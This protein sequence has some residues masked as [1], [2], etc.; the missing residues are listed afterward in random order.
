[1]IPDPVPD[2]G[3]HHLVWIERFQL[4][5][6]AVGTLLWLFH[7][8][9]ASVVFAVSGIGSFAFWHLHRWIVA[10]MLTP[11]VRK[12]WIYGFLTLFK[13]ALIAVV[14]RGMMGC[15]P[16]EGIA[17]TTGILVFVGG[18]FLETARLLARLGSH[19]GLDKG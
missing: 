17:L 8:W 16:G 1:M 15:F 7:S 4:L 13:L 2:D 9:R 11:M 6:I 12:R 19:E 18:I 14:L 5:L 10:R 3:M